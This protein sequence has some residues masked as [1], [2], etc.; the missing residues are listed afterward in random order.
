MLS[1]QEIEDVLNLERNDLEKLSDEELFNLLS[2]GDD[3]RDLNEYLEKFALPVSLLQSE[4]SLEK[5]AYNICREL[6][7]EGFIYAEIRF[8]PLLSVTEEM[9]CKKVIEALLKGLERGKDDFGVEFGVIT[10]A[11]RYHSEEENSKI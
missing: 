7:E 10:C 11:M 3:C 8:A 5:C 4:K 6:L 1:D 9:N 2:V